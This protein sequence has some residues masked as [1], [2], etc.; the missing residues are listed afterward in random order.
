PRRAPRWWWMAAS[1]TVVTSV[2]GG[3]WLARENLPW[4]D[5]WGDLDASTAAEDVEEVSA[6]VEPKPPLPLPPP[7]SID[8]QLKE[9]TAPTFKAA[10]LAPPQ[11]VSRP[12]T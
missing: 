7:R 4:L 10:P 3:V 1:A 8:L 12:G 5:I 11:R 9:P 6:P 2:G